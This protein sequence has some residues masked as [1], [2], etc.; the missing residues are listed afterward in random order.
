MSL[1]IKER[2]EITMPTVIA[3]I[4]TFLKESPDDR[5]TRISL[6]LESRPTVIK[7]PTRE[8][9][10][11]DNAITE[12]KENKTKRATCPNGTCL[13]RMS[14][15]INRSWFTKKIKKKKRNEIKKE[16][17]ASLRIYMK[18]VRDMERGL[19]PSRLEKRFMPITII[20]AW[21]CPCRAC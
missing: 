6:S 18:I 9:K 2:M 12:G 21:V 4:N 16:K 14:C 17:N 5:N 1:A 19:S 15:A 13:E 11:A 8:A 10:G 3:G 7:R 20:N